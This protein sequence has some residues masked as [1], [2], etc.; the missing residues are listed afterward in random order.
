MNGG[1]TTINTLKLA[2]TGT[3]NLDGNNLTLTGGG[4]LLTG[5]SP[6]TISDS[7]GGGSLTSGLISSAGGDDLII[8]D[9]D[10]ATTTISA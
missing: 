5:G 8:Q 3:F 2:G 9:Y 7:K 1:Q 10:T 6:Y 4:L